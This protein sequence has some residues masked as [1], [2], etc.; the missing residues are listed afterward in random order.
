[1]GQKHEYSIWREKNGFFTALDQ[2][3]TLNTWALSTGKYLYGE[4]Q[5]EELK[6][7]LDDFEVYRADKDDIT[8]TR[9]FYNFEDHS[10]NLMKSKKP[11]DKELAQ[12]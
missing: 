10:L 2:F 8:Y 1:M 4:Q 5:T 11:L 9:D 3:G 6:G 12:Q 7:D